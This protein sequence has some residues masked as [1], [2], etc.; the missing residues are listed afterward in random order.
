MYEVIAERFAYD[1]S[2]VDTGRLAPHARPTGCGTIFAFRRGQIVV[3]PI[4]IPFDASLLFLGYGWD[5]MTAL[6][7]EKVEF[8]QNEGGVAVMDTH[9]EPHFSGNPAG[10]EAYASFLKAMRRHRDRWCVTM[11]K[12]VDF[13]TQFAEGS[14][15]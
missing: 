4:T 9:P 3:V 6:W 7:E 5:A 8:I 2:V 10:L 12:L 15:S 14:S 1:S 13:V 11:G